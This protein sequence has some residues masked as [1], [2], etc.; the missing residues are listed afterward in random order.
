MTLGL[1]EADEVY[2]PPEAVSKPVE[3]KA[4]VGD[5]VTEAERE[6]RVLALPVLD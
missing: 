6:V 5:P 4:T 3:E 2:E 1:G